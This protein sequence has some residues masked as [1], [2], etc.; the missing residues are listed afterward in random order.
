MYLHMRL[1]SKTHQ[2]INDQADYMT[3]NSLSHV[4]KT[5][6]GPIISTLDTRSFAD[7]SHTDPDDHPHLVFLEKPLKLLSN[8]LIT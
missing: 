8:T 3:L 1:I 7:E 6:K 2:N 5:T 4:N